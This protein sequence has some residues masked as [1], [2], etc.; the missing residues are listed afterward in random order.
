[1]NPA[2][3][4]LQNLNIDSSTVQGRFISTFAIIIVLALLRWIITRVAL[5]KLED[6]RAR[7][8]FQKA[9]VYIVAAIGILLVGRVW[10]EGFQSLSTFLGLL[11]AG[12]AI[13]LKD[14]LVNSFGWVFIMWRRPFKLGDRIEIGD[15]AGDVIDIRLFQFSLLEI[16][17]WVD[18]DQSTGRVVHVP[19]GKVFT[20]YQANYTS[21]F[22]YIWNE[23]PVLV[24]FESDWKKAKSILAEIAKKHGSL[25]SESA[26]ERV[27]EAS[28]KFLIYYAK[29]TPTVYTHVV[30]SGVMLTI[31]YLCEPRSRRGS[32]QA[33]WEDILTEFADCDDIDFAYPSQRMYYNL[34]EGKP[35][36]RAVEKPDD[37][38]PLPISK[39]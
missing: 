1:M 31:R 11:T 30:D 9:T 39:D 13:A 2:A 35:G 29:L 14:A 3:D 10:F 15:V 23:I 5:R 32:L 26:Q 19:N 38:A 12:L 17:N 4:W 18:A 6:P 16:G 28:R 36:A 22:Q 8:Q 7:Y 34:K 20:E 25:Q 37:A 33:V 24:T 27:R 21:G